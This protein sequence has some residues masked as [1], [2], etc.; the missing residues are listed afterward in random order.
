MAI[1]LG[2]LISKN[3]Q[4]RINSE[5]QKQFKGNYG[6]ILQNF[7][8]RD[9][10]PV[11][12]DVFAFKSNEA[13]LTMEVTDFI[14]NNVSTWF[15]EYAGNHKEYDGVVFKLH[16]SNPFAPPDLDKK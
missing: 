6:A 15:T 12:I 14:M 10:Q 3:L 8:A 9:N 16:P 7:S 1:A 5:L 4:T 2:E 11:L 13:P